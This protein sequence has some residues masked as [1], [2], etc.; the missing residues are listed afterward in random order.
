MTAA[1]GGTRSA[2]GSFRA[3]AA[4]PRFLLVVPAG[5]SCSVVPCWWF[6]LVVP[7]G[8][9]LLVVP[10]GGSLL[11]APCWWFPAG[12]SLLVVPAD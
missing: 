3:R 12:G 5:G 8:G 6:L 9:S 4:V 1:T 11:V 7:A 2:L 10:A